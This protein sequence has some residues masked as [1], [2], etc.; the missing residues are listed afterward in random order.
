MLKGMREWSMTN[1][2]KKYG[3]QGCFLLLIGYFYILALKCCQGVI[4]KVQCAKAMLKPAVI[5][6]RINK[7]CQSELFDVPQPLKPWMFNNIE[8]GIPRYA[9]E[10]I[11]RIVNDLTLVCLVDHLK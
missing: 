9:Y 10:T 8:Y 2:V 7:A 1:I 11:N 6:S 5:R 4:H 3:N